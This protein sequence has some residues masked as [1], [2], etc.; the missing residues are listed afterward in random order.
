[1]ISVRT[2]IC[3]KDAC[4]G[5]LSLQQDGTLRRHWELFLILSNTN[6][7]AGFQSGNKCVKAVTIWPLCDTRADSMSAGGAI[8]FAMEAAACRRSNGQERDQV[9]SVEA[10][11]GLPGQRSAEDVPASC[12]RAVRRAEKLGAGRTI[13][14]TH[15]NL[16]L[17]PGVEGLG[18]ARRYDCRVEWCHQRGMP[19]A[20]PGR[21]SGRPSGGQ[22]GRHRQGGIYPSSE[23]HRAG[24]LCQ[25]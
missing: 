10:A 14:R 19:S 6:A 13:C 11:E 16:K 1:M 20:G 18:Y 23:L 7:R 8:G 4:T 5:C 9:R 17:R 22:A 2:N 25:V 12:W 21:C 24:Y 3:Y 15:Q